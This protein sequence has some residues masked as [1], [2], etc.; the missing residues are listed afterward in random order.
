MKA[1]VLLA[2]TIWTRLGL[3]ILIVTTIGCDR[4]TKHIAATSLAGTP[5]RSFFGD[6]LRLEYAENTGGFLS[7]GAGLPAAA[8]TVLFSVATGLSLVALT[9]MAIQQRRRGWSLIGLSL[10]VAG[11][12]SNW[13]DRLTFGRVVDFINIGFGPV[14]TGI[15]NVAD[16]AIM[17]GCG[18]VIFADAWK[19]DTP[20]A[21]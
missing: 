16:V 5:T 2:A 17:L 9:A 10:F 1:Y 3:M 13:L 14:R 8:R 15:F 11:G 19:K 12:A 18:L 4:V 6:S 21:P 7:L 20:T